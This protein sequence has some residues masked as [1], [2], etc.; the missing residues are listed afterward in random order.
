MG[1]LYASKLNGDE[2]VIEIVKQRTVTDTEGELVSP[3][4]PSSYRC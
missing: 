1:A 2:K 4:L 3:V